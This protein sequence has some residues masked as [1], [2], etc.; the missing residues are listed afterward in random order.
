M[1]FSLGII[2]NSLPIFAMCINI[3]SSGYDHCENAN[4]GNI[5]YGIDDLDDGIKGGV[6]SGNALSTSN[7]FDIDGK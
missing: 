2:S 1:K 3:K 7:H 5:T 6:N 4:D